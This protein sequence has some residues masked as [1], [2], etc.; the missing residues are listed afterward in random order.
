MRGVSMVLPQ[1]GRYR[2][3]GDASV[4]VDDVLRNPAFPKE[5]P[6]SP[7][8]FERQDEKD[9]V[10]FY[11]QKRLVAHIDER[12]IEALTD[13]YAKTIEPGSDILDICSS[14][15]S[16]FPKDFPDTMGKRVRTQNPIPQPPTPHLQPQ[17]P[18]PQPPHPKSQRWGWG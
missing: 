18:T 14:W 1:A 9:D 12:A 15:I 7:S 17:T 5:W 11:K 2:T 16:H 6:F 13:Y 4:T 10:V 8:D 3:G